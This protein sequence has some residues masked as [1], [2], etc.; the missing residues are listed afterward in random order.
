MSSQSEVGKCFYS[1]LQTRS[2][3][4]VRKGNDDEELHLKRNV[5]FPQKVEWA[6]CNNTHFLHCITCRNLFVYDEV[7]YYCY[8]GTALDVEESLH[9]RFYY[10]R[11]HL[12][13]CRVIYGANALLISHASYL[14]CKCN[15]RIRRIIGEQ[16]SLFELLVFLQQECDPYSS[17]SD[18]STLA[19]IPIMSRG[20]N[21]E[22][23]WPWVSRKNN[24][25]EAANEVE[26]GNRF[27][28]F[29]NPI[30]NGKLLTDSGQED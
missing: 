11:R 2:G 13:C 3:D 19:H 28:S 16:R 27:Y 14:V 21:G 9:S 15:P 8:Y 30:T 20:V 1:L 25:R 24:R 7:D 22:D 26:N 5:V 10:N 12:L 4:G 6:C 17:G 23:Q 29:F 18:C